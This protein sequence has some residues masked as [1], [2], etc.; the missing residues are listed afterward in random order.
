MGDFE[1]WKDKYLEYVDK[2]IDF[3]PYKRLAEWKKF[4][5]DPL[6]KVSKPDSIMQRI[7][8]IYVMLIITLFFRLLGMLPALVIGGA[9]FVIYSILLLGIPLI[10]LAAVLGVIFVLW[11]L[12]PVFIMLYSLVEY[13]VAKLLGG[14]GNYTMHFNAGVASSLAAFTFELPLLI[15]YVPLGWLMM[16]PCLGYLFMIAAFP[17]SMLMLAIGLYGIYLKFTSFRKLHELTTGKAAAVVIVPIVL[18]IMALIALVV[19]FYLGMFAFLFSLPVI[20][21]GAGGGAPS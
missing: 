10:I 15:V 11:L 2:V 1:N 16:I 7:K 12:S 17:L 6:P 20:A 19:M 21:A 4:G 9:F 13:A 14:T 3:I 18:W 5:L 8:D